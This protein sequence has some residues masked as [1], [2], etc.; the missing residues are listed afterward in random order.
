MDASSLPLRVD[1]DVCSCCVFLPQQT[2]EAWR[3]VFYLG[4]AVYAFGTIFYALLGSGEVQPWAVPTMT[5][6]LH[7]LRVINTD[8]VNDKEKDRDAQKDT[9]EVD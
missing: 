1:A 2:V 5:E 8:E 9:K 7:G 4:G 6:E 3:L